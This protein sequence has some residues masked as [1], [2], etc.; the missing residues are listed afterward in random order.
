[1]LTGDLLLG[2]ETV[3]WRMAAATAR[4]AQRSPWCPRPGEKKKRRSKCRGFRDAR[5]LLGSAV[6]PV[7]SVSLSLCAAAAEPMTT[8]VEARRGETQ[9]S[10]RAPQHQQPPGNGTYLVLPAGHAL[11]CAHVGAKH[12][13]VEA[14]E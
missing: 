8:V 10:S 11:C 2:N 5:E 9:A 7:S 12:T 4:Q 14:N 3:G 6:L 13:S 1:V